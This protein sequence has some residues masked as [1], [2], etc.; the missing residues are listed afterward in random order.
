MAACG[1]KR[2]EDFSGL[3]PVRPKSVRRLQNKGEKKNTQR[4]LELF[5]QKYSILT[6]LDFWWITPEIFRFCLG[7]REH[8]HTY[9][10][11]KTTADLKWSLQ[12]PQIERSLKALSLHV[13]GESPPPCHLFEYLQPP[14]A[15]LLRFQTPN[16]QQY[17]FI[18]YLKSPAL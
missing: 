16:A 15:H 10:N 6:I 2:L 9:T 3:K 14:G 1:K 12:D 11:P 5:K 18:C 7:W 4:N 8:Q 17:L 13:A